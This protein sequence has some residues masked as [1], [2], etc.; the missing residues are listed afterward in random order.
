VVEPNSPAPMIKT[1]LGG[2]GGDLRGI[3][4]MAG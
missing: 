2:A 3:A 1:L 4:L